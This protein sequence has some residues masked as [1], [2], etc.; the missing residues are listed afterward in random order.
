M[1][2]I[3]SAVKSFSKILKR[4]ERDI[5]SIGDIT[6]EIFEE[7][8]DSNVFRFVFRGKIKKNNKK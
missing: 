1:V 7:I 4:A 2:Y 5:N 3:L 6:K 8:L